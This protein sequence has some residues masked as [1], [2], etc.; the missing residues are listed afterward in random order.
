MKVPKKFSAAQRE[1]LLEQLVTTA[2]NDSSVASA[3]VVGSGAIGMQDEYSDIDLALRLVPGAGVPDAANAWTEL[4]YREHGAVHHLD[5]WSGR[6]LYRVFLLKTSL[7]VDLS[8]W[9][10]EEFR[11]TGPNFKLLFGSAGEPTAPEA[12]VPEDLVG[13]GWLY[14]LHARSAIARGRLWQAVFMLDGIRNQV[15]ALKCLRHGL[16]PYQGRGVDQLP[17]DEIYALELTRAKDIDK[18]AL[19]RS[20]G[21]SLN[22]LLIEAGHH[23]SGLASALREPIE[24]LAN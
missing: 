1:M 4:L 20:L 10:D 8:F 15:I 18:P 24:L 3:A 5:I 9:P 22:A 23:N 13:M 16:S 12:L 21:A 6:A 14:G 19:R 2:H 7:Q 11:A 17:S